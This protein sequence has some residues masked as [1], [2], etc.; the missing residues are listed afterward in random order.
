MYEGFWEWYEQGSY[1]G[2]PYKYPSF[3][4]LLYAVWYG[5][6]VSIPLKTIQTEFDLETRTALSGPFHDEVTRWLQKIGFPRNVSLYGLTA[7]L[8][9]QTILSKEEEPMTS[10]L[11]IGLALRVAQT[12]GLHRDPAQFGVRSCAAETR[13]RVWWHIVHM[14]W[15]VAMSS[16][17]PPQVSDENYW[18][19][20]ML[21]E[22]KDTAIE[23]SL[24][25]QYQRLVADGIG[26]PARPDRANVCGSS[27][28][29]VH[30]L[31]AKGKCIMARKFSRLSQSPVSRR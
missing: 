2:E 3:I 12:M 10:G 26:A 5:A 9:V 21:S 31:S 16:G 15:V 24:G 6:S 30:Y 28:V 17:L 11:F 22:L 27:M 19:V 4:P 8:M 18:D 20:R 1:A 23:T 14:D 13:R 7:F 25:E 29:N